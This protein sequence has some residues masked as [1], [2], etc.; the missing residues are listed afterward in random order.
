MKVKVKIYD[1]VITIASRYKFR[2][3]INKKL[4]KIHKC[5]CGQ[6]CAYNKQYNIW[7]LNI[8]EHIERIKLL[9]TE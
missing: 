7:T 4:A 6:N 2:Q 5:P 1:G 9:N 3:K 8:L